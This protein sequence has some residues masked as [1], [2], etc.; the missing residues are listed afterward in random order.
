MTQL[1]SPKTR[2]KRVTFVPLRSPLS[3]SAPTRSRP[4]S[5]SL[6]KRRRKTP[7]RLKP[8]KK[9]LEKLKK[10]ASLRKPKLLAR[11]QKRLL[12]LPTSPRITLLK[13]SL[14]GP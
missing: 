3:E 13:T 14:N 2:K 5:A 12:E 8:K 6:V 10:S 4:A 1:T 7:P 9:L 11:R